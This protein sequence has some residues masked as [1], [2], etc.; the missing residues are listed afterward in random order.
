MVRLYT[1]GGARGNP[2]PAA[3]GFLI[4]DGGKKLYEKGERLGTT[5]NNVA[6]YAAIIEGLRKSLDFGDSVQVFSDSELVVR[7]LRGEYKVKK[8]HLKGLFHTVK[9]LEKRFKEVSYTHRA[10]SSEMQKLADKL[11]NEALDG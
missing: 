10:R 8:E 11:V 1:D 2:G 9:L 4:Y 5:T 3:Y 6:E 7:Q